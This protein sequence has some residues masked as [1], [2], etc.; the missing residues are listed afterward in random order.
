MAVSSCKSSRCIWDRPE[1]QRRENKLG[2]VGV[3]TRNWVQWMD[4]RQNEWCT[5]RVRI[6]A[7]E[8]RYPRLERLMVA[9]YE[10]ERYHWYIFFP[11]TSCFSHGISKKMNKVREPDV[12]AVTA[13][14]RR[15]CL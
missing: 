9:S 8:G 15:T 7:H 4:E 3:L 14:A 6:F 12:A 11:L 10:L 1:R 5:G 2:G 13:F